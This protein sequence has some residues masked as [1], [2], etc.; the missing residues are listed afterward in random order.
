M[1]FVSFVDRPRAPNS[2]MIISRIASHS[3]SAACRLSSVLKSCGARSPSI[4]RLIHSSSLLHF[5]TQ[6]PRQA[7]GKG[8]L[9]ASPLSFCLQP[10]LRIEPHVFGP[11]INTRNQYSRRMESFLLPYCILTIFSINHNVPNQI[12][13]IGFLGIRTYRY[14]HPILE[15]VYRARKS[16]RCHDSAPPPK[17]NQSPCNYITQQICSFTQTCVQPSEDRAGT[18]SN[19]LASRTNNNATP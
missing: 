10:K 4:S 16:S 3:E 19:H 11:S 2:Q 8:E 5:D 14:T 6:L 17:G 1:P 12:P 18:T 13:R 7:L 9:A 15:H